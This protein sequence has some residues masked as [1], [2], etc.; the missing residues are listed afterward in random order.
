VGFAAISAL[1]WSLRGGMPGSPAADDYDYLYALRFEQPLDPWGPMGSVW[2]WRPL[3]RQAYFALFGSAFFEAPLVVAAFH[4]ALLVALFAL[5]YRVARRAFPPLGAASIAAFP[6][7]AEPTR[8]LVAWPTGAQPLL[9]MVLIALA[10]HEAA[11]RRVGMAVAALAAALLCHEQAILAAPAVPLVVA[12]ASREARDRRRALAATALVVA[13]YAGARALAAT[14]GAGLPARSGLGAALAAAPAV[15]GRSL[16]AQ[17]DVVAGASGPRALVAPA[18]ALIVAVAGVAFVVRAD[19]R[20][21]LRRAAPALAAGLAWFVLGIVPLAFAAEL[22]TPRHTALPGLGLGLLAAGLLACAAPALAAAFTAIRLVA[23]LLMPAASTTVPAVI[24]A[25]ST[26]LSYLHVT[27]LQRTAES[28]RR[29]LTAGRP[30]LP[31]GTD[32]R[33]WSLPTQT[34]VAFAGPRAVRTWYGDSTLTWSFWQRTGEVERARSGTPVLGFNVEVPDPAVLM[35]PAAVLAYEEGMA[36]WTAGDPER[37]EI[38]FERAARAQSPIHGNF[39]NEIVR[40]LARLA[41]IRGDSARADS[42]AEVDRAYAG[43]SPTYLAMKA[44]IALQKG[45]AIGARDFAERALRLRPDEAD[46]RMVLDHLAA[47]AAR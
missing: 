11:A 17:L 33:Y 26:P 4:G 19:A 22:W 39:A 27:R 2:Y 1:L 43:E 12:F 8:A 3:S 38:A 28:A 10:V 41:Y 15:F 14:H 47:P 16:A 45:D 25:E 7:L 32:V 6:L 29:V 20:A 9:A 42:L 23:L 24:E 31:P 30:T 40:F 46:A 36:A 18:L 44:L 35:Q 37:A 5:A 21:R 34:Q 13:L